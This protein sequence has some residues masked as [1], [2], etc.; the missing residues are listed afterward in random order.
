[1]KE[2][3]NLFATKKTLNKKDRE[4]ILSKINKINMEI[5]SN[6]D[7][8]YQKFNEQMDKTTVEAKGEIEAFMQNKINS[9]ANAALVERREEVLQLE[10]PIDIKKE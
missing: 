1:M 8:I 9:I 7:F 10:N 5:N 3:E 2:V 6:R 4:E